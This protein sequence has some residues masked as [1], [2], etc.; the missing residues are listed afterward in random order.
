MVALT[1]TPPRSLFT[2]AA[3]VVFVST[4]RSFWDCGSV[5][6]DDISVSLGD[7]ELTAG[8]NCILENTV[9]THVLALRQLIHI[10]TNVI[11]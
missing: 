5:A 9:S 11:S 8:N 3:Q 2:F 10:S 6:L 7:C 4:C 1:K